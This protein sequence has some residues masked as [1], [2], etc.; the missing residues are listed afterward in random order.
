[1]A[2]S[3]N[4]LVNVTVS[5]DGRKVVNRGY[6]SLLIVGTSD[7]LN[8]GEQI[9]KYN[10]LTTIAQEF[11]VDSNEYKA[12]KLYFSQEPQPKE[13]Y[14]ARWIKESTESFLKGQI[15][16]DNTQLLENLKLVTKGAFKYGINGEFKQVE[17]L[18]LSSA[19]DLEAVTNKINQAI[20]D[21]DVFL[22]FVENRFIL[23][24]IKKGSDVLIDYL[25]AP[26]SEQNI[27]VLLGLQENNA[28]QEQ[29]A[30]R[31]EGTSEVVAKP[32]IFTGTQ[33]QTSQL[34]TLKA[35]TDGSLQITIDGQLIKV[36]GVNLSTCTSMNDIAGKLQEKL[37]NKATVAYV[38]D[39][40]VITTVSKTA[41]SNITKATAGE[42][43]TTTLNTS[44][45]LANGTVT[46][47][48]VT[49]KPAIPAVEA[50]A[51]KLTGKAPSSL[52][53][54]KEVTDGIF[55]IQIDATA[56]QVIKDFS[57]A[58]C[59][60]YQAIATKLTALIKGATVSYNTNHFEIVSDTKGASSTVGY[61]KDVNNVY[62]DLSSILG[63]NYEKALP[64]LRG[65][66]AE[67]PLSCVSRLSDYSS[68]WYG[69]TFACDEQP[70]DTQLVEIA[71]F[72]EAQNEVT[73]IL[74]LTTTDTRTL[75][76]E[77]TQDLA[78]RCKDL[79]LKRTVV[80]YSK[81]PF[82]IVSFLG[83]AFSV[84]FN[85]NNTTITLMYKNEPLVLAENISTTQ[86]LTLKKKNCNV[87]T[88]YNNGVNILQY[89]TVANG[90]YFDIIHGADW[91]QNYV[92]QNLFNF[93]LKAPKIGVN[94]AEFTQCLAVVNESLVRAVENGYLVSGVWNGTSIGKLQ[95]GDY[96]ESG[97]YTYAPSVSTLSD[98][99]LSE[100]KAPPIQ[101]ACK[102]NGALHTFDVSITLKE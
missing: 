92:Q 99:E 64:P 96:L 49:H 12:S 6:G 88:K 2:L 11:G 82:A 46:Q 47:K 14:I 97:F 31:V 28:T 50:K 22:E 60:N 17:D 77:Y 36:S 62:Q 80:Q 13:L 10:D 37:N 76:A 85:G 51:G 59:E 71:E 55:E 57:F 41:E 7:V 44:L 53:V 86:A 81:N 93:V 73:R 84:N 66:N 42:G 68:E 34:D 24:T 100:R 3:I 25:K 83:R 18:D 87:F 70:S 75:D 26:A 39:K 21:N 54:L 33:V 102:L 52:D 19:S 78:S 101:C 29:G 20:K 1:M 67:T 9:R 65:L 8:G 16:T 48:G 79:G 43:G 15:N 23:K 61:M 40:F 90:T 30:D 5:Y 98:I 72:I 94:D 58:E 45:G 38:T 35:I 63:L 74:G 89:G 32:C 91:L 69:L 4:D 56:K 27:S 95:K